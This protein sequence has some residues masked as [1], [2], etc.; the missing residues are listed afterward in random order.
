MHPPS[1]LVLSSAL[2]LLLDSAVAD[3]QKRSFAVERVRNPNFTGRNGPQA[4]VKTYRKFNMPLPQGLVDAMEAQGK[5]NA[6]KMTMATTATARVRRGRVASRKVDRRDLLDELLI[7]IGLEDGDQDDTS[8]GNGNGNENRV[9]NQD[10]NQIPSDTTDKQAGSVAAVPE[11]NDVEFISP[12]TIGG[13]NLNLD[14][15][16]GSSDLWVFTTQLDPAVRVNRRVYNASKSTTFKPLPRATFEVVYGDR[17]GAEGTVGTDVVDVGGVSVPSQAIGLATAVSFQFSGD[18]QSDGI[19]GLAFSQLNTVKPQQ[20]KTFFENIRN[21]LAEPVFTVDLRKGTPGTYTFG[22]IDRSRFRGQLVWIPVNTT[23]GFWQ[24]SSERFAIMNNNN[25]N[26]NSNNTMRQPLL[27]TSGAQAIADTGSTLI[28]ADAKVVKA[29]Y[30]Q[31]QGAQEDQM[32]AFTFPCNA[33]LPDLALDVG[34][35]YMATVSGRDINHLRTEN[36][37]CYGGV[38][39][40]SPGQPAVFGDIFFKSQFVVFNAG[41]NSL[42]MAPHA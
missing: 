25:N 8:K 20:Q 29:Y 30:A 13:Q 17:S 19:L 12:V 15:D 42:G 5:K 24:F 27:S 32:E 41:N 38:Q 3:I 33:T 6:M 39:A 31:V 10:G 18:Q 4:L 35:M 34:N 11:P 26:N 1:L 2:L 37:T 36:G 16:T 23:N 21:E 40:T 7:E 14:F 22:R 28:L 9:G